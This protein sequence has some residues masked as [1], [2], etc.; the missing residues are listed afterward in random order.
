MRKR[1]SAMI[2]TLFL[3]LSYNIGQV[4]DFKPGLSTCRYRNRKRHLL[5]ESKK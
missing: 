3:V 1:I 5:K 2:M 4:K